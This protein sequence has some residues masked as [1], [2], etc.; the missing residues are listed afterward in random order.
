VAAENQPGVQRIEKC[1]VRKSGT[2]LFVELHVEVDPSMTIQKGH[3][4]SHQVKAALMT[5]NPRIRMWS[6][7]LSPRISVDGVPAKSSQRIC[8]TRGS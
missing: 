4:V 8:R 1:L 3:R 7:I 2:Q 6:Y 5:G